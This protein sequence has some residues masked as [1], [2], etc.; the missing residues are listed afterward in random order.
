MISGVFHPEKTIDRCEQAPPAS[1]SI[2]SGWKDKMALLYQQG[3]ELG[4]VDTTSQ[5]PKRYALCL[6]PFPCTLLKVKQSNTRQPIFLLLLLMLLHAFCSFLIKA[7]MESLLLTAS[8]QP[9]VYKKNS[10]VQLFL[11][12]H[13]KFLSLYFWSAILALSKNIWWKILIVLNGL[14]FTPWNAY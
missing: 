2:S 3:G 4:S 6:Q 12:Q 14:I 8:F 13:L 1:C 10:K 9:V 7:K 5:I 11:V